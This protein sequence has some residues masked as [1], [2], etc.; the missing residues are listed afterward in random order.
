MPS[1]ARAFLKKQIKVR[2]MTID[3]IMGIEN[4]RRR[5]LAEADGIIARCAQLCER[6]LDSQGDQMDASIVQLQHDCADW[7]RKWVE[8]PVALTD[9]D[10]AYERSFSH[11]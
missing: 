2:N 3:A 11:D 5:Q 1:L 4:I 10:A 6:V 7:S 9:A 8:C